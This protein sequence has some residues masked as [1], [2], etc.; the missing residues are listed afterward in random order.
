MARYAAIFSALAL[1]GLALQ[2][3]GPMPA[4]ALDA[5]LADKCRRLMIGAFPHQPPGT[6]KGIAAAQRKYFQE[7]LQNNGIMPEPDNSNPPPKPP[8]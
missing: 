5:E 8:R 7:C 3:L 6:K 2:F 1:F 4:S